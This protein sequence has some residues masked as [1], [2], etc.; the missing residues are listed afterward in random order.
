M[1]AQLAM[2]ILEALVR[3]SVWEQIRVESQ[4]K[5][6]LS[7]PDVPEPAGYHLDEEMSSMTSSLKDAVPITYFEKLLTIRHI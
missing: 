4:A 1:N 7:I 5:L 6:S 2:A 3:H